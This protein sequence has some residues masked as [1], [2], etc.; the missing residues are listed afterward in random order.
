MKRR[1]QLGLSQGKKLGCVA[2]ATP[3]QLVPLT[4]IAMS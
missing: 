1:E 4:T 3:P 2:Q